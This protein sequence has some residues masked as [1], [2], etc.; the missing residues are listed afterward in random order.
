MSGII[1]IVEYLPQLSPVP[2]SGD[3]FVGSIQLVAGKKNEVDIDKWKEVADHPLIKLR[4]EQ[5]IIRV[6]FEQPTVIAPPDTKKTARVSAPIETKLI[7]QEASSE[8]ADVS[9]FVTRPSEVEKTPTPP[10][11]SK[12]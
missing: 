7:A 2:Q 6:L 12:K 4:Q 10:T 9:A 11:P 8:A 1:G 3:L 5:G